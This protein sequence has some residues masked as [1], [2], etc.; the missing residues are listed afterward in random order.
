MPGQVDTC[1]P[2]ADDLPVAA[3]S[4]TGFGSPKHEA[5]SAHR[6]MSGAF[7]VPGRLHGRMH[8]RSLWRAV[9]G[10]RKAR[11]SSCRST[12]RVPSVTLFGSSVTVTHTHEDR[13]MA[14]SHEWA[15]QLREVLREIAAHAHPTRTGQELDQLAAQSFEDVVARIGQKRV[16]L[17]LDGR[18]CA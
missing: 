6:R 17:G 11:R 14:V 8:F 4:A 2:W 3:D 9:R 16:E 18:G 12:N 1:P 5:H 10:S 15:T 13:N 7:Y